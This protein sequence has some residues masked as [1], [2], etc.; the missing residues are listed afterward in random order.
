MIQ[1]VREAEAAGH[2][3]K[4]EAEGRKF[5]DCLHCELKSSLDNLAT[6]SQIES[7]KSAGDPL[8]I[9]AALDWHT[10]GLHS[11]SAQKPKKPRMN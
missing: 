2:K 9:D 3:F 11:F 10:K 6:V 1:L 5:K 7:N 8:L 4:A